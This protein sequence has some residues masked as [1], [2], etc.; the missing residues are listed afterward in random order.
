M[1]IKKA[2]S[3]GR[4][5]GFTPGKYYSVERTPSEFTLHEFS[6]GG[7]TGPIKW[8]ESTLA[9]GEDVVKL[10]VSNESA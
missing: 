10:R 7:Y 3:K 8:Q 2:D 9:A 5:T 4:V 1:E 6:E